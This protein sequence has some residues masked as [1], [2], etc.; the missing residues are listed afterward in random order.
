MNLYFFCE[1]KRRVYQ[2]YCNLALQGLNVENCLGRSNAR[3]QH[4][5]KSYLALCQ[6]L[7]IRSPRQRPTSKALNNNINR[8][9]NR[10]AVKIVIRVFYSSTCKENREDSTSSDHIGLLKKIR[11]SKIFSREKTRIYPSYSRFFVSTSHISH[12]NH[13]MIATCPLV[14]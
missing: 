4:G 3:S 10:F 9:L 13:L 1:K 7:D 5:L 6:P 8:V 11:M 14:D 12:I 2:C